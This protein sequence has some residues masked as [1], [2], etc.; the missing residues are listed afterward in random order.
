MTDA[1]GIAYATLIVDTPGVA[2]VT[3]S[4]E[5]K[6]MYKVISVPDPLTSQTTAIIWET[7]IVDAYSEINILDTTPQCELE[8]PCDILVQC[9]PDLPSIF[10]TPVLHCDGCD[11]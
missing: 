10:P 9:I 7:C 5:G 2:N 1:T 8:C 6:L 11:E 4:A 3:A